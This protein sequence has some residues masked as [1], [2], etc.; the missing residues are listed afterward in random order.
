MTDPL[1]TAPVSMPVWHEAIAFA[2]RLH[3]GQLRKDGF[4]PYAAHP[5]RVALITAH[6]FACHDDGVI[7]AAALHDVIEDTPADYD[8]VAGAFGTRVADLVAV[9]SKDH[10][11]AGEPRDA[12]YHDAIETAS[13]DAMVIKLADSLDNLRDAHLLRPVDD[14]RITRLTRAVRRVVRDAERRSPAEDS[15]LSRAVTMLRSTLGDTR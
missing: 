5:V 11:M 2:A 7:A 15:V 4:T 14:A 6:E 8:D 13:D 12:A 10:R 1:S 9:L 3:G